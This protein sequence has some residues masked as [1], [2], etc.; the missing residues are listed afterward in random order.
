MAAVF[1]TECMSHKFKTI[2]SVLVAIWPLYPAMFLVWVLST[3]PNGDPA[4]MWR[5][6]FP[7]FTVSLA[8]GARVAY[9]MRQAIAK[10]KR[11][12]WRDAAL[13]CLL[14]IG[15]FV[16]FGQAQLAFPLGEHL[17]AKTGLPE[18]LRGLAA[19]LAYGIFILAPVYRLCS[20][21]EIVEAE[22]PRS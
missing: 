7:V 4:R 6:A 13:P 19:S 14:L 10:G 15:F 8:I 12:G 17:R 18:S 3:L 9:S 16:L 5:I 2:H 22:S 11:V 20:F 1:S 21:C